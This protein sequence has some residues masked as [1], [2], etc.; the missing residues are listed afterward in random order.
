MTCVHLAQ[1]FF[2][3]VDHALTELPKHP[4]GHEPRKAARIPEFGIAMGGPWGLLETILANLSG[5]VNF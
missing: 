3:S 5:L 1:H 4:L 2:N